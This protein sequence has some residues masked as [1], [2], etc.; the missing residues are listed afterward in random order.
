MNVNLRIFVFK[1]DH[2]PKRLKLQGVNT[3]ISKAYCY[4]NGLWINN[5]FKL[6]MLN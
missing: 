6:L 4:K 5:L 3:L 2:S 1:H